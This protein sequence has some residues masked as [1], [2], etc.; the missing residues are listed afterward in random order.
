MVVNKTIYAGAGGRGAIRSIL[1][2]YKRFANVVESK[3]EKILLGAA[4]IVLKETMPLV[5][6]DTGALRASGRAFT[7]KTPKGVLA[8]VTFGGPDAP[9][10]ATRNAPTGIV[11]YAVIVH[12]DL[13]AKHAV[14]QALFLETGTIRSKDKIESYV[15]RELR[16]IKK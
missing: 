6:Y 16:K 7:R 5:P 10:A 3:T 14:G 4:E 15:R 12:N 9:V 1:T 8:E 11:D 2:D 13:E